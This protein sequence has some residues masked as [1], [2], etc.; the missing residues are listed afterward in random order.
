MLKVPFVLTLPI[1]ARLR[2]GSFTF[3]EAFD[4]HTFAYKLEVCVDSFNFPG[5]IP[6]SRVGLIWVNRNFPLG[7]ESIVEDAWVLVSV[8]FEGDGSLPME[9]LVFPA[10]FVVGSVWEWNR[11]WGLGRA[12]WE[13]QPSDIIHPPLALPEVEGNPNI[14]PQV[15]LTEPQKTW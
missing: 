5:F 4:E 2:E 14:I 13:T 6:C 1:V 10:S 8:L 15:N 11:D 7:E 12:F 3:M 9:T